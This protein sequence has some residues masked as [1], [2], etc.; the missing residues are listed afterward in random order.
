MRNT[1]RLTIAAA[2]VLIG[3]SP[4][5]PAPRSS[6]PAARID[7]VK[8]TSLFEGYGAA[9]YIER[10]RLFAW[11]NEVGSTHT[12]LGAFVEAGGGSVTRINASR[13]SAYI[14]GFDAATD[15][16]IFQQVRG[17]ESDLFLYDIGD[18]RRTPL[19]ALN[20]GH[21]QWN[22]SID[23]H[24]GTP[25]IVYGV[26]RFGSAS[27]SW[28]L[29]LANGRTGERTLLDSTT[30]RCGC[31]FPGT[32]AYPWVTWAVGADATAWRYDIRTGER[33]PLLPTDRDEYG[34]AVTPD[35]TAYVAQ[36][37]DRC[38]SAAALYRVE[39]DGTPFLIHEFRDRREGANLSVESTG[40]HDR[41]YV[42]RRNCRTGSSDILRLRR[43]EDIGEPATPMRGPV[44]RATA[45]RS[46][47][48][49]GAP[50]RT[51]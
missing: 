31:M 27:A 23:T 1:L 2:L 37:G 3:A 13:T 39:P 25:W 35:G 18:R 43:A 12:D 8:G 28:R 47:A 42:D 49:S 48:S 50:P 33:T 38:G 44:G 51:R 5:A 19:R 22:P 45:T 6:A 9:T 7:V 16:V 29:Y 11:S 10:R 17:D 21:W 30:N 20:D 15:H 26:N 34:V 32:V 46:E 24:R 4:A 41:L 14:G 36:S 40:S